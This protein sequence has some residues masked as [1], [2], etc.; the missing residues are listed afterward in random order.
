MAIE[1]YIE[2]R[3]LVDSENDQRIADH[4][5][6]VS[7]A[8]NASPLTVSNTSPVL[9]PLNLLADGDS[10]FDYPIDGDI[11]GIKTDV[12]AQLEKQ[13]QNTY[14][15]NLAHAGDATTTIMGASK[16]RR[17][18]KLLVD[19]EHG[20]FDAI[21]FSAGGDDL[22]GDQ[23]RLWLNDAAK[24]G[25]D[26]AQAIN[27]A[28]L[29]DILGVGETGYRDLA[30]L[31]NQKGAASVPIITHGYDFATPDG[32]GVCMLGP[33][34]LPSLQSRG[35]MRDPFNPADLPTGQA[36]VKQ[37]L[38]RFDLLMQMLENDPYLNLIYVRTQGTLSPGLAQW[39][40]EL[41]PTPDGFSAIAAKFAVALR[42]R[43]PGRC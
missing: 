32:S 3:K 10:W 27:T 19:E 15:L 38:Q 18:S 12:I 8:L 4:K 6:A 21:L 35:W 39:A 2:Y 31:R 17:L 43:F 34:L 7:A 33:W 20:G 28:A 11:P 14:I 22:V 1:K 42:N 23:F 30:A 25:N 24:V 5:A 29:N 13:L 36:I 9:K 16:Y 26:P 40:N 41:H 37:M